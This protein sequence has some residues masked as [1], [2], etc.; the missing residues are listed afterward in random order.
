MLHRM[1]PGSSIITVPVIDST[2]YP[3][4]EAVVGKL[5]AKPNLLNDLVGSLCS[6]EEYEDFLEEKLLELTYVR[7]G[8]AQYYCRF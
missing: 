5:L 2:L 3:W 8:H 6:D 4:D 1:D 7:S